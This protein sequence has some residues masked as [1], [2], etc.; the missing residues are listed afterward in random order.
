MQ[1]YWCLVFILP[2]AIIKEI[3][4]LIRGFLWCQ[5]DLKRGKAKVR[6]D[7]VCLSKDE[8]GLGI[9]RLKAWNTA[10]MSSLLWRLMTVKHSLWVQWTNEH[11]LEGRNI[12]EIGIDSNASWSWRKLTQIRP[13][14]RKFF[15]YQVGNG[16]IA[17]VWFD[18]W[19]NISPLVDIIPIDE[20]VN[21]GFYKYDR[22]CDI[23]SSNGAVWPMDWMQRY[24]ELQSITFPMFSDQDDR[25]YWKGCDATLYTGSVEYGSQFVQELL[26]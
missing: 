11:K 12:W 8:G 25:L 15:V 2:N 20:I 10:L 7:D 6:W 19:C 13:L 23:I 21:D 1:I 5:G 16:Q 14:I 4:K 26:G 18:S 17:Y 24:P 9:K 22:V 3:E